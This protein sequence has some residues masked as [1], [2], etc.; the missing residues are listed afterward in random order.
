MMSEL[1][2]SKQ[3]TFVKPD[4]EEKNTMKDLKKIVLEM[5]RKVDTLTRELRSLTRVVKQVLGDRG[6][7]HG[8]Q[9]TRGGGMLASRFELLS[10]QLAADVSW[11]MGAE[12]LIN[13]SLG[14]YQV[15]HRHVVRTTRY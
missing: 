10:N 13:W 4:D 11:L 9:K 6:T 15:S 5:Q 2:Y 3:F 1:T 7:E 12:S 14:S 8:K